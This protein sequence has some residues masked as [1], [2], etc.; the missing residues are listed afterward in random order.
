MTEVLWDWCRDYA[1]VEVESEKDFENG[2][3]IAAVLA[4]YNQQLHFPQN[5]RDTDLI[6]D[7]I[8][9]FAELQPSL[10][11]LGIKF[12]PSDAEAIMQNRY[13]RLIINNNKDVERLD[14]P[15]FYC[16]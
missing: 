9:N 2:Y 4:K 14:H 10:K 11:N 16:E 6:D 1:G 7:H 12:L 13:T 15:K 3:N 8:N 5:F